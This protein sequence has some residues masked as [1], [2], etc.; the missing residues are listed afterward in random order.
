MPLVK[1]E[2]ADLRH[3]DEAVRERV[4]EELRRQNEHAGRQLGERRFGSLEVGHVPD[5]LLRG[6][7][8]DAETAVELA[9]AEGRIGRDELRLLM[10][11]RDAARSARSGGDERTC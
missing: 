8:V 2:Q 10:D 3:R 11:E 1:N 5:P 4:E 6:P 9:D 7:E